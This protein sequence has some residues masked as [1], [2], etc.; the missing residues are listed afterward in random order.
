MSRACISS[1]LAASSTTP[2][3]V[4]TSSRS[5]SMASSWRRVLYAAG[6]IAQEEFV[7]IGDAIDGAGAAHCRAA[8]R[9][10]A[11][12]GP[13]R[14]RLTGSRERLKESV[15]AALSGPPARS[16]ETGSKARHPLCQAAHP[17]LRWPVAVSVSSRAIRCLGG[18]C[19]PCSAR[20]KLG[21][22][23]DRPIVR[24][25][26]C[27]ARSRLRSPPSP[28]LCRQCTC[29]YAGETLHQPLP[30]RPPCAAGAVRLNAA[31][32]GD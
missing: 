32:T 24:L 27:G 13:R 18:A 30:R 19:L 10:W 14:T 11:W 3:P 17:A 12:T 15:G 7:P 31:L 29:R 20:S 21:H 16:F 25:S 28:V 8:P 6:G 9:R 23:G 4:N 5:T 26:P 2:R 22:R 1:R